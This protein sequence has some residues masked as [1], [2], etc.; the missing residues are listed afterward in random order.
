MGEIVLDNVRKELPGGVVAVDDVNM[1]G[2]L[3][4]IRCGRRIA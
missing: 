2:R 4:H 1:T 3:L